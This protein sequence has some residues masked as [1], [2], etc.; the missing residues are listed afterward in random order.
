MTPSR[1]L[2]FAIALCVV[3]FAAEKLRVHWADQRL[4]ERAAPLQVLADSPVQTATSDAPFA[5]G[6]YQVRPL[7][8]FALRARVLSSENYYLGKEA[9]L[10][11]IDL[12][13][14][15]KRMA[16]PAVYGQLSMSQSG[17]WF[18]Y[19][20]ED[21]PP[22]PLQEIN[23]SSANMHMIAATPAVERVLQKA[24]KGAYISLTG[25]LVEVT[26]PSGWRWT[27]SLSRTDSGGGACELM[28]VEFAQVEN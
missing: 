25:K 2:K 22:I 8:A 26:D 11:H 19:S 3:F 23:E 20:W 27:S 17:R 16:D 1:V 18:H 12:A 14:G 5:L 24:R 21:E 10:S 7:A 4:L 13:L 6:D 9:D 28:Y 15:W